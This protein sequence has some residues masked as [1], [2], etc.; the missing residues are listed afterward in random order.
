MA[1]N[2][3]FSKWLETGRGSDVKL[4]ITCEAAHGSEPADGATAE[5]AG[6]GGGAGSSDPATAAGTEGEGDAERGPPLKR[7]R[8]SLEEVAAHSLVLE[9]ASGWACA[10]LGSPESQEVGGCIGRPLM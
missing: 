2:K 9:E 3:D 6:S 7:R 1:P 10:L 8:T 4:I 5:D